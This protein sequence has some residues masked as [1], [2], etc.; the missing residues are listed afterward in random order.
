MEYKE[1]VDWLMSGDVSIRYQTCRDIL[2][3]SE[4]S[5]SSLRESIAR[6]GFGR[7]FMERQNANGHWDRDFYQSKWTSTHYT[8]LDLR[9]LCI[10]PQPSI[11]S[12]LDTLLDYYIAPDG[13]MGSSRKAKVSDVCINGMFLNYASYFGAP[14]GKMHSIVDFLCSMQ[15]KDGG[16]NCW[17]NVGTAVHS[18]LH[19]TLSVLEGMKEYIKNGYTYRADDFKKMIPQAVEFILMHRLYKSDHTGEII[20]RAFTTPVNP[21]R[22]KYDILRALDYMRYAGVPYDP[23][24]RDALDVIAAKRKKDGRWNNYSNYPGKVHFDME[25]VGGPGRWN[26]LRALRVLKYYDWD[27]LDG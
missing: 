16:F 10:T 17:F 19:T 8:L 25:P 2:G 5:L 23:R 7:R 15:M 18:S 12:I 1:I 9:N 4:K 20:S 14:E 21:P 26:T 24:M 22:W 27:E 13:G 6:E 3:E 11:L